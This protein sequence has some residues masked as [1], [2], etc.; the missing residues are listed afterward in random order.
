MS[1]KLSIKKSLK[2]KKQLFNPL[3][4]RKNQVI[5]NY[6]LLVHSIQS[7]YSMIIVASVLDS[8]K[9]SSFTSKKFNNSKP[10]SDSI[11]FNSP[12]NGKKILPFS[13]S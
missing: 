1:S 11:D 13:S 12:K 8:K 2:R 9:F 6:I 10:S 7:S 4:L 5:N 3:C